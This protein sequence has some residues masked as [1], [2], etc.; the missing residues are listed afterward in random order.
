MVDYPYQVHTII[1]EDK[2]AG[3]KYKTCMKDERLGLQLDNTTPNYR[4]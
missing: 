4:G 2:Q 1:K 3:V